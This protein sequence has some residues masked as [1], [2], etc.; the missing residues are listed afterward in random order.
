MTTLEIILTAVGSIVATAGTL[1]GYYASHKKS[2]IETKTTE[3]EANDTHMSHI[4]NS[5]RE[6][7]RVMSEKMTKAHQEIKE[8]EDMVI[9]LK[10]YIVVL[11]DELR[12]HR[13]PVPDKIW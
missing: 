6:L 1:V 5:Y 12:K 7:E 2:K 13:I 8:L 9:N 10:Q 11:Q 3:V 4:I